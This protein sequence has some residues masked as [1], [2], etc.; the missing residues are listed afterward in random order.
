MAS[1]VVAIAASL[2]LSACGSQS[3]GISSSP[4]AGGVLD[5]AWVNGGNCW[6]TAIATAASCLPP[7]SQQGTLS[8]DGQTCTYDSGTVV[9]FASPVVVG[10]IVTRS[11][12]ALPSFTVS[13]GN[14]PCLGF[15]LGATG[16]TIT[17]PGGAVTFG[18]Q[19]SQS[20][21][22]L[23][24]PNGATYSGP[25]AGIESCASSPGLGLAGAAAA[26]DGGLDEP[27]LTISLTGT[28][29]PNGTTVF[30]CS[31]P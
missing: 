16:A 5:C 12:V 1:R 26:D 10:S 31:S 24:C 11:T 14:T 22:T 19:Q 25:T 27:T 17:T 7:S 23:I 18:V 21:E 4:D 2:S 15:Q 8:A 6:K 30:D 20:V 13:S 29:D 3:A 28:D 9:A